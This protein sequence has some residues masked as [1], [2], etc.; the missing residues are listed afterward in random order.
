MTQKTARD[1]RAE[2][3]E[4]EETLRNQQYK[5][6]FNVKDELQHYPVDTDTVV[7][8]LDANEYAVD[9]NVIL[10]LIDQRAITGPERPNGHMAWTAIDLNALVLALEQRR[11]WKRFSRFHRHKLTAIE[12]FQ[13]LAQGP[14]G[15]GFFIDL[16]GWDFAG[17]LGLLHEPGCNHGTCSAVAVAL[18][19]K[20]AEAGIEV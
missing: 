14:G 13:E 2:D 1:Y 17:L 19:Q 16:A 3:A 12:T 18:E 4:L 6:W 9:R 8:L 15:E 11:M 10:R 20:L 7:K 5:L